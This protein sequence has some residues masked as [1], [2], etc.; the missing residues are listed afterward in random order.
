MTQTAKS[1]STAVAVCQ[2]RGWRAGQAS[3]SQGLPFSTESYIASEIPEHTRYRW[4]ATVEP[5]ALT[6][7]MQLFRGFRFPA[8]LQF[9]ERKLCSTGGQRDR[10]R[11]HPVYRTPTPRSE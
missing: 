9:K 10:K 6:H 7:V 1:P 4:S 5:R 8:R 2:L 3:P 11:G